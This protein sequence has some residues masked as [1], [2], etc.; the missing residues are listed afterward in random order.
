MITAQ[1][2]LEKTAYSF[3]KPYSYAVPENYLPY[4]KAGCRV[5]VPFGRGNSFRQGLVLNIAETKDSFNIKSI[6]RVVDD[7]PILNDEMLKLCEWLH[8]TLFCT[9]FDVVSTLLPAGISLKMVD[10]LEANKSDDIDFDCDDH[11]YRYLISQTKPIAYEKVMERFGLVDDVDIKKLISCGAVVLSHDAV[12]RINDATEQVLSV[13]SDFCF[14]D[15]KLT[16]KQKEV[17]SVVSSTGEVSVKEV[18]YFTGVSRSVINALVKKGVLNLGKREVYRYF[19]QKSQ[20]FQKQQSVE[21]NAEQQTAFEDLKSKLDSGSSALIYGVTG[22]GKTQ[23][24]LKLADEVISRGKSV[25]VMV[26]EISLTPQTI[27]VFNRRYNGKTAIFHSH[28]SAGRRMEEWKRVKSGEAC[29]AIGTRS[30]V[31]APFDN[32]GLIIMDEEQEHTYKS[33]QSPR[34]HARDIARFRAVYHKSLFVMASATPSVGTYSAALSGKYSMCRLSHRFGNAVLPQVLIAD[35]R[36][37][38][39]NGNSGSISNILYENIKTALKN[40]KQAIVLLNRRGHNTFVTCGDC[41]YVATCPNCSVSLTYHSANK[42]LMCHYCG[43]SQPIIT[44]CPECENEYIKF[45][46]AGTQKIEQ[47]LKMLFP[48]AGILRID[49]DSTSSKDSYSDYLADFKS[50]KYDIMIGTQMVAKGLD[51]P[52]VTVVGVLGA[53]RSAN[54]PDYRAA[55]RT[56]SLLTQVIGRAGRGDF[57]GTAVIQTADPESSVITLAKEQDYD[58]FYNGEIALR[59]ILTYPPYCDIISVCVNSQNENTAK[60]AAVSIAE[61]IKK[62]VGGEFSQ[63]KLILLGPTPASVIKVNGKYRFMLMI[64]CKNNEPTRK[65]L[66]SALDMT[67]MNGVSVFVDINPETVI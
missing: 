11:I 38:L 57:K 47:E 32:L 39:Q 26:P 36:A 21:L 31:F 8:S 64:K 19:P 40:K 59:K 29:I 14:E 35:M 3:D 5:V 48:Q 7:A 61:N 41:G 51:F 53:D 56:F 37:E 1:V 6:F 12:R 27:E 52:N 65:L 13:S 23:V 22:S 9:Y 54:S 42:R 45:S 60:N 67:N 15:L 20:T 18:C 43:Y 4:C 58:A 30:A 10:Y 25:I 55:E 28:M 44:K 24:F 66:R 34:F 46:G 62:L 63:V 50:G 33:E 2:V 17:L 16:D 49:A